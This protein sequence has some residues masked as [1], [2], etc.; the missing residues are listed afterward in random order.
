MKTFYV[1]QRMKSAKLF[2]RNNQQQT[3]YENGI[4]GSPTMTCIALCGASKTN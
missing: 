2:H 3:H 1:E 4:R